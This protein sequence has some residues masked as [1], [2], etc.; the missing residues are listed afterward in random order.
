MNK[1]ENSVADL[2][3]PK[4]KYLYVC[5]CVLCNGAEVDLHT[6][7]K[8]VKEEGLWKSK[9]SKKH[10]ENA[11]AARKRKNKPLDAKPA[12][13]T[14][15]PKKIKRVSYHD[16][17]SP[18]P[19]LPDNNPPTYQSSSSTSSR[20]RIPYNT[21]D[22][23]FNV[24]DE[25]NNDNDYYFND[26]NFEK[27]DYFD[28]DEENKDED[29]IELENN[30]FTPPEI[31]NDEIFIMEGLNDSIDSKIIIWVFKFQQRFQV[32]DT[33]LEALIKFLRVILMRFN[34]SIFKDFPSSLYKVQKRLKIFQPKMQFAMCTKCH[35][36]YNATNIIAYEQK[37]R[38]AIATCL[39][40]EFPNNPM[41]SHRNQCNNPLSV[42]KRNKNQTKAI[43]RMLYPKPSIRQQLSMLYQ[44]PGFEDMLK[45]SG[46]PRGGHNIYSDIYDGRVW[47]TFPFDGSTFF[48]MGTATTH[49]GLL[50]NLDW[51][52][53]FTHT[54]HS[55]GAIYASICNLLRSKRSKPENIIYLSFLPDQRKWNW[56]VSI[57]T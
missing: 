56:N 39:N 6:Q 15:I 34:E 8:H 7:E 54:Q 26:D 31:D 28:E 55:T 21:F 37:G 10:Q 53:P 4:K 49:L 48:T 20:F 44:Q 41:P 1:V 14:N 43:P 47:K 35:K 18:N 27:D 42:F 29:N 3:K 25:N 22:D 38:V 52:Q 40:E 11:I 46:M 45:S 2:I 51:F 16:G 23:L 13:E 9:D 19:D 36:L 24:E 57:I 50:F 32:S 12:A 33:A 5:H 30:F 17:P